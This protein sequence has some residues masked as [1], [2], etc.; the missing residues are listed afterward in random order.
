MQPVQNRERPLR[1]VLGFRVEIDPVV[2]PGG[3]IERGSHS[4][5]DHAD[6]S[7][8]REPLAQRTK[9][10]RGHDRVTDQVGTEHG[11]FHGRRPFPA[12]SRVGA[13]MPWPDPL[14][15]TR[16]PFRN[17]YSRNQAGTSRAR[18]SSM[19][20]PPAASSSPIRSAR[21]G[22]GPIKP[23]RSLTK[24]FCVVKTRLAPSPLAQRSKA[25]TSSSEYA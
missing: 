15:L 4:R 12:T 2:E 25:P 20:S 19:I 14:W 8:A 16:S 22:A 24:S 6:D 18:T 23:A 7:G 3:R 17:A 21:S 1:V 5:F 11:D 10:W 13:V 9:G